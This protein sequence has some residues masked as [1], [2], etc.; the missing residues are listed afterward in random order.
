MSSNT[1]A[2]ENGTF[3]TPTEVL[4]GSAGELKE[5]TDLTRKENREACK[6]MSIEDYVTI[7]LH[8]AQEVD[9]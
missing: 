3:T 4:D 5:T 7:A 6:K 1:K 2:I 9:G 8:N